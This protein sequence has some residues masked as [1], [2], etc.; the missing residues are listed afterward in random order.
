MREEG[1]GSKTT[2]IELPATVQTKK[3][4]NLAQ[5]VALLEWIIAYKLDI[6]VDFKVTKIN[7]KYPIWNGDELLSDI[8][9]HFLKP[10]VHF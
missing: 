4:N 3:K 1:G 10:T 8:S 2:Y 7:E 6:P 5:C 9:E